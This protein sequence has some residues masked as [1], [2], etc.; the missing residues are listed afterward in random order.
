MALAAL[1]LVVF[2][3]IECP[4]LLHTSTGSQEKFSDK[5]GRVMVSLKKS[6]K[7]DALR[8]RR[9]FSRKYERKTVL[10]QKMARKN[11]VLW[12]EEGKEFQ[13]VRVVAI[14]IL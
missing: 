9:K 11:L 1:A 10:I 13:N 7:F 6:G 2:G 4:P 8:N 5:S 14:V 3:A 12:S